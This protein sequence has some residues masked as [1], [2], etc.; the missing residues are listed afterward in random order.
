MTARELFAGRRITVMGLGLLGRGLNDVRFLAECGADLV[1]TD[2]RTADELRPSLEALR[3]YPDIR[4]VLGGHSLEDFRD[5]DFILKA[6]GVPLDSPYIAEA[7]RHGVAIEMDESLFAKHSPATLV[8]VTG[9]RGKTTVTLLTH[10]ILKRGPRR[11][12]LAGNIKGVATLPFLDEAR[13]DDVVVLE[14]SSWQL[15]GFGEASVSPHVA[16]FTNFLPD[17]LNYYH[18]SM[19]TYFADKAHIFRHQRPEDVV[20]ASPQAAEAIRHRFGATLPGR[21]VVVDGGGVPPDWDV[22]LPGEHNRQNVALAV[23]A[24][25][26]L[27]VSLEAARPAVQGFEGVPER[28]EL[29]REVA[30]VRYYNDTTA[31]IPEATIAALD[32][33]DAGGNV[34][35]VAGGVDKELDYRALAGVLCEKTKAV[36]L[37]PGTATDKILESLGSNRTV[38]DSVVETMTEAVEAAQ[39]LARDGDVVLLSPGAASFGL[40]RNEFD[41]GEQFVR[42]VQDLEP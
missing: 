35:L 3:A 40:F 31:T 4:Y 36:V 38:V 8:G 12:L 6:A 1:V 20:I 17:H 18:R 22:A 41:R 10:E 5:R 39:R 2:L 26:V 29:V 24:A 11:P 23:A 16:V 30:G 25:G 34:V 37:F 7:R 13:A 14:L 33:L 9:T 27:G 42:V 21:L 15:Q 19:D 28:L 32:A